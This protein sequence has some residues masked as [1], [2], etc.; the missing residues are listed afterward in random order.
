M[1]QAADPAAVRATAAL[2]DAALAEDL[3]AGDWTTEC[4][5]PEDKRAVATLV[6][7]SP[8]VLCGRAIATQV[9]QRL[10][11][12]CRVEG[13][14]DGARL[15]A[16]QEALRIAG[17]A[18]AILAGERVALNFLQHLSGIAT[19][20]AR[21]VDAVAGTGAR[22]CDTRKTT[23]LLRS[24]EKEAVR[25]GGGINHRARL[26]AMLLV[27]ENH[28][29]AAGS[30]ER[31]LDLA[32]A[33]AAP[34][35]LEVEIEVRDFAQFEIAL[36]RAPH[37]ILLDHWTPEAVRRA[38]QRRGLVARPLLEVSGNLALDTVRAYAE[39]GAEILSVGALTHSAP[40][41][42]LSLLVVDA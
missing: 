12:E 20:T 41:L 37:R 25:C 40:A 28:I 14:T 27:K 38:V 42:D 16:G 18:R 9:F 39:A 22:I 7:K 4:T 21:Y 6:A 15:A 1:T 36:E 8:G 2:V 17:P 34:R 30:L 31:A 29:A 24:L 19:L 3:G 13:A 26:D 10:A 5:V 32:L 23:P 33:F 11:A 35:Q